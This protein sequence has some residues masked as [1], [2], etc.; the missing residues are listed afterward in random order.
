MDELTFVA[1]RWSTPGFG[2]VFESSYVNVLRNMIER[3][4]HAPWRLVC[5]TD[6]AEGLDPRIHVMPQP[7]TFEGLASPHGKNHPS[8]YRKLWNFSAA[9]KI[10]GPRIVSTDIDVIITGDI[11]PVFDRQDDLVTWSD[12]RFSWAKTAGGLYLL[13]TGTHTHVW[14]SFD[15]LTSPAQA[16]AAGLNG[17]D[18]GWMSHK[19]W[20]PKATWTEDDGVV[21]IKWLKQG[22][23]LPKHVRFISTPGARKPWGSLTQTTW[24]WVK[25]HWK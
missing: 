6:D 7:V 13:R 25:D 22:K 4:Y 9:A 15:P 21:S 12:P 17:S 24:P 8:C 3:H 2:R 11:T 14:D 1:W 18:Q 10:L 16:R 19:L 20:P 23:P 5:I